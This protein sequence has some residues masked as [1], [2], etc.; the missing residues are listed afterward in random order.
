[1]F[2]VSRWSPSCFLFE[3]RCFPF[4]LL[5]PLAMLGYPVCP[6][7]CSFLATFG[8]FVCLLSAVLFLSSVPV[9]RLSCSS[10]LCLSLLSISFLYCLIFLFCTLAS[11]PPGMSP[12]TAS[13]LVGRPA[14]L[15]SV[16]AAASSSSF[17]FSPLAFVLLCSSPLGVVSLG[18]CS[19][20]ASCHLVFT[21][22]NLYSMMVPS[23]TAGSEYPWWW[24]WW[25]LA[26]RRFVALLLRRRIPRVAF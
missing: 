21:C 25:C 16:V 20:S 6:L 14:S 12:V 11:G 23:L 13:S 3:P 26:L 19:A 9:F 5:G 4:F 17:W 10:C 2:G 7:L 22:F 24:W 15:S 8:G 18:S 1:M